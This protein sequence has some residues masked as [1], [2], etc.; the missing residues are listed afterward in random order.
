[1]LDL[2]AETADAEHVL[3]KIATGARTAARSYPKKGRLQDFCFSGL[4]GTILLK[5]LYY[6]YCM[7]L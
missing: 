2:C 6:H 4:I 7:L 3:A 5:L 1:M